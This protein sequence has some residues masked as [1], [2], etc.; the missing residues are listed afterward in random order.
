MQQQ[1]DRL[2]MVQVLT[3]TQQ[4]RNYSGE[5]G[6]A[7]GGGIAQGYL[8]AKEKQ[9]QTE[10]LRGKQ[11]HEVGLKKMEQEL[12][13]QNMLAKE[14]RA[15]QNKLNL[16][17]NEV[18]MFSD[19]LK[20]KQPSQEQEFREPS[21]LQESSQE[22]EIAQ[23]EEIAQNLGI[24]PDQITDDVIIAASAMNPAIGRALSTVRESNERKKLADRA[25]HSQYT[26]KQDEKV[27]A[28]RESIPRKE[29]A[30]NFSRDA[31]NSENVSFFSPDKLAD[32]TGLD[33]FRTAKGAQLI[34]AGKENLLSNMSRVSAR[35]QNVW[36]EQRLNSV[37]P[38]IGQSVEA[39][40]T[41]QE[42]IEAEVAMDKAYLSAY[43]RISEDDEKNFGY[44]RSDIEKRARA[45]VKPLENHIMKRASLRMKELHEQEEGLTKMKERVGEN[46]VRGTPLTL[47]MAKLY[48][49][50]FGK[51][52]ALA[53]AEKNGYY[54]PTKEEFV[55][56]Q[57]TPTEFREELE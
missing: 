50:K 6:A 10:A 28:L 11:R 41:V 8:S 55:S 13:G 35:A 23:G 14:D 33:V 45:E 7:L 44:K 43:D 30:L 53:V 21:N 9:E 16:K 4:K 5:L 19:L 40:M 25:Y 31:L 32:A 54:I 22:N 2:K 37:F 48:V 34:A 39:N 56:F 20:G 18:R 26:L 1:Q 57:K 3:P 42:M 12:K 51:E 36:F 27:N 52:N 29:M 38:K 24:K 17:K 49:N 15:Y 47:A 46:V